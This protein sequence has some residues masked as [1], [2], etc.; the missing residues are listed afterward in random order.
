MHVRVD[1]REPMSHS[2]TIRQKNDHDNT[3]S[4]SIFF[5]FICDRASTGLGGRANINASTFDECIVRAH[6]PFL[7]TKGVYM[8]PTNIDNLL[9]LCLVLVSRLN[10]SLRNPSRSEHPLSRLGCFTLQIE[11]CRCMG[12]SIYICIDGYVER[13]WKLGGVRA[14]AGIWMR[15]IVLC[16]HAYKHTPAAICMLRDGTH[17]ENQ[18]AE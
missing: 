4:L 12:R 3:L 16:M 14:C 10:P 15:F 2:R 8:W 13:S 7:C 17:Y 9:T 1:N 5:Y 11:T 6:D 18:P